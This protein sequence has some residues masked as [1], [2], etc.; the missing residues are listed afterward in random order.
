[1]RSEAKVSMPVVLK[2]Q[3]TKSEPVVMYIRE[4]KEKDAAGKAKK[5]QCDWQDKIGTPHTGTWDVDVL[6][7]YN[8]AK[9]DDK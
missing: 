9:K 3:A 5:V 4:I 8:P 7:K 2:D 6:E 1:M